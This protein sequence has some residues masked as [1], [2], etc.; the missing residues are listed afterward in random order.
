MEKGRA[1]SQ[2]PNDKERLFDRLGFVSRKENIIQ[3]ETKPMDQGSDWPD[4][5]EHEKEYD[6]LASEA[7]GGISR[8]E[9]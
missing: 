4:C 1:A 5:I 2:I 3:E 8:S 7:G 6:A 9:K